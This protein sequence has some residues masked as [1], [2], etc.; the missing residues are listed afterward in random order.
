MVLAFFSG[1][2]EL[3]PAACAEA[4]VSA[5]AGVEGGAESD[6]AAAATV[7]LGAASAV[8]SGCGDADSGAE[9]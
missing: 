8:L 9:G 1:V 4:L 5:G 2:E 3:S 7:V 6:E